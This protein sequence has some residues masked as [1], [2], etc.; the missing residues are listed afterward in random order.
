[1]KPARSHRVDLRGLDSH[2]LTWGDPGAPKL[3]L[4]HGWMDVAASFQFLVDALRARVVRDRAG[5]ARLRQE[6]V[7]AAG[8][9]VR[10]LRR[11]PR[12]AARCVRARRARASR[13]PQPRRQRR[14][15]LRRACGR[16]ACARVVS[17][18]GF[19]IRAEEPG[20]APDKIA[21][22]LDA[23]ADAAGVRALREP[24]RGRRPAAEEQPAP[25]ARQGA[26]PRRALG[27]G[28]ARRPRAARSPIRGTSCRFRPSTGSRRPTRCGATSRRRRC[29]SP[30]RT[31]TSRSGSTIIRRA[32]ARPTAS[33]ASAGGSRTSRTAGW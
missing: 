23:L 14:D 16:R 3:F 28:A 33:P 9:L 31:R 18:D 10:R 20:A 12:G 5:P 2:V 4:L 32:R 6:R 11:R 29:G 19:G 1:M 22:W 21:K 30:R 13:G 8:L 27:R 17:L 24:R 7:A 15:A 25:A 26:V